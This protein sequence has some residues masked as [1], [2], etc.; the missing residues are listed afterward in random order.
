MSEDTS[1]AAA[2]GRAIESRP[3]GRRWLFAFFISAAAVFGFAAGKV[4]S[5]PWWHFAG[6]RHALDAEEID[7]L[8]DHRVNRMLSNVDATPEQRTKITSI[9]KATVNDVRALRKGPWDGREKFAGLLKADSIDRSALESLRAEQIGNADA[10][11][12]R[13]VQGLADVAEVL[14]PEQ[15]RKIIERWDSWHSH[16]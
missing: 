8:V 1:N 3:R 4:H 16:W 7:Y 11:T 15:R 13:V 9:V 6:H 10:A 14:T 12:K 5:A 2:P